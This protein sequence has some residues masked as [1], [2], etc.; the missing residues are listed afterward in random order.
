QLDRDLRLAIDEILRA[1][2]KPSAYGEPISKAIALKRIH[3][4]FAKYLQLKGYPPEAASPGYGPE[5]KRSNEATAIGALRTIST[6]QALSREGDKDRNGVLDY[7]KSLAALQA[8]SIVD[9]EL[10]SGGKQGYTFEILGADEFTWSC[11]T[12]PDEPGKTG[13]RYFFVD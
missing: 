11:R 9:E 4:D 5:R 7:A 1:A 13:D 3:T 12:G 6:A 10:G 2:G 8:C